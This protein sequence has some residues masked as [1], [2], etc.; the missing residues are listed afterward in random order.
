MR[1]PGATTLLSSHARQNELWNKDS[2]SPLEREENSMDKV[3]R[4][5]R[6]GKRT[7]P[8]PGLLGRTELQCIF[9]EGLDPIKIKHANQWAD[10]PLAIPLAETSP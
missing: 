5:L 1:Q 7:V 8:V 6:C 2:S 4:C 9:C 3:T 10:S